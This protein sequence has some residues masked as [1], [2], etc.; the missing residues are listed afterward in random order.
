VNSQKQAK[1]VFDVVLEDYYKFVLKFVA[2]Q[3]NNI[4]DAKDLTQDIFV[5]AYNNYQRYNPIKASVKTWLFT[6]ANNHIINFWKSAYFNKKS[7]IELDINQV[8][9][10]ED[11][12]ERVIQEEDVKLIL[13]LMSSL[14]NK[15]NTKIMNLYFF[16]EMSPKEIAQI[17]QM[18]QKTVSNVISL[19]IKKIKE[20]LEDVKR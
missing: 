3:V 2:K 18:N 10:N 9:G 5:K 4:E 16:S 17:L 14:L 7:T 8:Q 15:R 12:L 19:S 13:S 20:K 6:I 1:P 11:I